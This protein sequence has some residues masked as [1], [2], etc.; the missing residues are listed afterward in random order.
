VARG[1]NVVGESGEG[2]GWKDIV[3]ARGVEV[4]RDGL[5]ETVLDSP[6]LSE[7]ESSVKSKPSGMAL[8]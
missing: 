7:L 6:P 3:S 8:G 4:V 2:E 5:A 1:G